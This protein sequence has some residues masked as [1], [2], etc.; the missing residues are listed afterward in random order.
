MSWVAKDKRGSFLYRLFCPKEFFCI[1]FILMYKVLN[2]LSEYTYFYISKNI[3]SY[4]FLFVSKFVESLQCIFKRFVWIISQ[5]KSFKTYSVMLVSYDPVVEKTNYQNETVFQS[6]FF[7]SL[8][9]PW[10]GG[11]VITKIGLIMIMT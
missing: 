10:V 1:C 4:T 3:T 11:K 8:I 6:C 2:T 9:P 7:F 5:K